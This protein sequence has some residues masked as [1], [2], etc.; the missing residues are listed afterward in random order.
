[1][2]ALIL[3]QSTAVDV[4]MGCF[5]DDTDGKT[6]ET[7]LTI[8]QADVQLMKN[9]GAAAQKNDTTAA[10]HR[11]NGHYSVPLNATDTNTVGGLLI[12]INESGALPVWK[13]CQVVEEAVYDALYAASATGPVVASDLPANFGDMAITASTGRV[14]VGTNNDKTG[15]NISGTKQ[16]LDALNDLDAAGVRSAVG[17]A[18]ANLDT[19]LGTIDT[20]VDAVVVDTGTTIPATLQLMIDGDSGTY[21]LNVIGAAIAALPG[22][23]WDVTLADHLTPGSTG[24]ALNAAGSAGD[25]WATTLPGSYTGSQAGAIL[26]SIKDDTGT[27]LPATLSTIDGKVDTIDTNVDAVLVD[28]G[29]TIPGLIA[30]LNDLDAAGVRGAVGL[31]AANLD[32]QLGTIDANVDAVLV[33]TGTTIPSLIAALNDLDA[34]GVRTAIGLASAN[35][36]TQLDAIPTAIENADALLNRDMSAVSDTTARSP[37]NALRALR[38]KVDASASPAE[39]YKEDDTTIAWTSAITRDGTADNLVSSDPA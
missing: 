20:N 28:T 23:V 38:N 35:L 24:N 29:T 3:K 25:P 19:Q 5:V 14:T 36:D 37:L 8:S 22:L 30:A 12:S 31:S 32:T 33:D 2:S 34:A 9:G 21:G 18:S 4:M 13:D 16:T 6:P 1:M 27:L 10:T 17:L 11:V 15:Y 7:A 26:P 39:V